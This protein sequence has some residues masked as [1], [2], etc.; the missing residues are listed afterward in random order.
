MSI[1]EILNDF[2]FTDTRIGT[3]S[4]R[5]FSNGNT[6]PLVGVPHGTNYFAVQSNVD[7]NEWWFNPNEDN[8]KGFRLTHQPSPWMGD[9]SY[10]TILPFA[11]EKNIKYDTTSSIFRPNYNKIIYE[12]GS[13]AEIT[14]DIYSGIIS[15]KANTKAN[16]LIYADGLFLEKKDN[17]ILGTVKNCYDSEDEDFTMYIV[18]DLDNDF[19]LKNTES[20]YKIITDSKNTNLYISTSFISID[21]AIINH[22]RLEKDFEKLVAS[23]SKEWE[24]VF[25]K[26]AI[27]IR[28][29][30]ALYQKYNPYSK[31]KQRKFFYH[32]LY[33]AYLF[34][35][36]F[37]EIDKDGKEI[38]Y[39]TFNKTI[40][41]GML[42]TNIG[43]WDGQKTLFPLLSLIDTE[44]LED[45]LEGIINTY[46]DTGFLP[47][48]LSPDERS[49]MPGTLVDN[50]IAD[51][52]SKKIG[53]DKSEILLEA[54]IKSANP[55]NN[56]SKYG[57]FGANLMDELGYVP[58]DLHESVN[59]TLDNSLSDF[60]IGKVAEI[61]T[62]DELANTYYK[63]SKAYQNL[64]DKDIGWFRSKDRNGN[65]TKDFDKFSWGSPYTEGSAFQNSFNAYHDIEGIVS[66]F[67]SKKAF[68]NKLDEITNETSD[69]K[70][71]SYGEVIHEMKEL[72]TAHFGQ[73]AISNQPS[74]HLPYL[75]Y[76]VDKPYKT[77]LLVKELLL[78]YFSYDFKGYPGDE[79]NGSL[80]S[81]FILSSLGIYPVALGKEEYI[82]GMPFFD[83]INVKLANKNILKI[84]TEENYH[85]KKFIKTMKVNGKV[86]KQRKMSHREF[87]NASEIKFTLGLVPETGE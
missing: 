5:E 84:T 31:E 8:F 4:K 52:L 23:T 33:R 29:E 28:K 13:I 36:R 41:N 72:E 55:E 30:D 82:I 70:V 86:Y 7:K 12:D 67:G 15:Y 57:R 53:N 73:I 40:K 56:K 78:N 27:N 24:K 9:Y 32:C 87:I 68:E 79:D 16:F 69:F 17:L 45:L 25:D 81:W 83:E 34:P 59:Q 43:F 20:A 18:I 47:K 11:L 39:D 3:D 49:M 85:Q 61:L 75:Y 54:M 74:F 51:L 50:T 37:F 1:K 2:R 80:S 58:A 21:Q 42:F 46:I 44:F 22:Q 76:Y 77:Q 64:F 6:L 26:F 65:F 63:K 14:N 71:G 35:M 62:K 38:H 60:S 19:D 10:L 66:L 48:W